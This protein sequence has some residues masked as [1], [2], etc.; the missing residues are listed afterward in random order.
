MAHDPDEDFPVSAMGKARANRM[1]DI[2]AAPED[3]ALKIAT[4]VGEGVNTFTRIAVAGEYEEFLSVDRSDFLLGVMCC[5]KS[6]V[7]AGLKPENAPIEG[8]KDQVKALNVEMSRLVEAKHP[9][10]DLKG[11]YLAE[12]GG[13]G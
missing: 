4:L 7:E 9:G 13:N 1:A 11:L 12:D 10:K 8:L 2:A 5:A 3:L 6:L